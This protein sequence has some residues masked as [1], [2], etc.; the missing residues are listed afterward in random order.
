MY[1]RTDKG[2]KS[3]PG[4][5][6]VRTL[7][8]SFEIDGPDDKHQCLVHTTLWGN[9]HDF[10]YRNPDE[11]LPSGVLALTLHRLFMALDYLHSECQ[12]IHTGKGPVNDA[13]LGGLRLQYQMS[14]HK[15]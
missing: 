6:A 14:R 5:K 15:S 13:L 12:I 4:R 1:S 8:D 11:R 3:H 9:V 2:S 7:L 10:L